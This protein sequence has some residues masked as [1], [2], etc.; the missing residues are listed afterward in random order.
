MCACVCRCSDVS[1]IQFSLF[2]LLLYVCVCVFIRMC[3]IA[4]VLVSRKRV[5]FPRHELN[6]LDLAMFSA[7]AFACRF[8]SYMR[9][10]IRM[11]SL[12]LLL[13]IYQDR[14]HNTFVGCELHLPSTIAMMAGWLRARTMKNANIYSFH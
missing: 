2:C 3:L 1:E 7:I 14:K 11:L 4:S 8:H 13:P 10:S 12:V 6:V 9:R 5:S